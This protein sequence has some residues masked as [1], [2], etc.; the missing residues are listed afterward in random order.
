MTSPATMRATAAKP[1]TS[2]TTKFT[3]L[4][5]MSAIARSAA[6]CLVSTLA[7]SAVTACWADSAVAVAAGSSVATRMDRESSGPPFH[8][9]RSS[10]VAEPAPPYSVQAPVGSSTMPETRTGSTVSSVASA[11]V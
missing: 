10:G 11:V 9:V 4:S 6:S 1:S 2:M 8:R 5:D 7:P 3:P